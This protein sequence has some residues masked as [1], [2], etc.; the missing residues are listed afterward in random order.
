LA[1]LFLA[2]VVRAQSSTDWLQFNGD[3]QRS[4]ANYAETTIDS[5]NV[6]SLKSV[7]TFTLAN[8]TD[9]AP[10]VLTGV[11][12]SSGVRDLLFINSK[13][14]DF[15]ALDAHTG[16]EIWSAKAAGGFNNSSPAIDPNRLYVY[17]PGADG[18]VHKYDVATGV[19]VT[20]GGFPEMITSASGTKIPGALGIATDASGVTRLYGTSSGF[21]SAP[22]GSITAIDLATGTQNVFNM[23]CSNLNLHI[24]APGNPGCGNNGGGVWSRSG[25]V[26]DPATNLIYVATAEF[27]AFSPSTHRWSQTLLA[28]NPDATNNNGNPVDSNTPTN[29][30]SEISGDIDYGSSNAVVMPDLPGSTVAHVVLMCGKDA[31]MRLLNANNLSGQGGPGH[32]GGDLSDTP[33][34]Q[35]GE[36]FSQF[37]LWHEPSDNSYWVIASSTK[38]ISGLIY[39]LDSANRPTLLPQWHLTNGWVTSPVVANS[40]VFAANEAGLVFALDVK[41]G[42]QLWSAT[43]P[44]RHWSSPVVVNGMLYVT[45]GFTGTGTLSAFGLP[46]SGSPPNPP[47]NLAATAVSS[48]QINLSWTASTT[49]GVTYSIFRS[50]TSGFTPSSSN[51]ITS[52]VSGTTYSD[53][54][55]LTASTT[56]F[57]LAEAVGSGGTSTKSNQASATTL[58]GASCTAVPSAPTALS[59]TAASSSQINLNWT[60]STAGTGCS[61]A[62]NVYSSTTSGFTPSTSNQIASNL[63]STSFSNTGLAASTTY[64]Y[65]VEAVDSDGSSG[66]SNQGSATTQ[67]GGSGGTQIIAI[68]AGG[69]VEGSFVADEDFSGGATIDHANTINTSKVTNPAPAAVYQSARDAAT[70]APFS[71]TIPGFVAGDSYLV[72]LH[73][74]ETFFTTKGSRVFNVSINGT[75]VL[76]N[77]DIVAASGGENIAN[78]QQFTENANSSGQFVISFTSVTNNALISGIEIDSTS[79]TPPPPSCTT[80]CIDSGSTTGSAP[81]VADEDFTSGSTI[82]HANTIN[83]SEVTNPA[84]EAV[85]QS[86]R[87]GAT[88]ASGV[89]ATFSYTI[90]G[91]TA[92]SSHTVRLHFAETFFTTK[93]SRVFNV[94]INGTQVLTNFDI[95]A[96]AGGENIANIQQFPVTA[97]ASGN[98]TITFTSVTNN[99]LI[100][101]IEIN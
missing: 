39:T 99:A 77:F 54:T 96:A 60:A 83:L 47:T 45:S 22:Y 72:R 14:G 23:V 26:Y 12:T 8:P 81:F 9:A 89:G 18:F 17:M 29:Y 49:S 92:A 5:S 82:D 80:L 13:D 32:T 25:E 97:D 10:V 48:S 41:T 50:T 88:Q 31:Q 71:Y 55:G 75:Q 30:A 90:S 38:G 74:A 79:S 52:D 34:P 58:A 98:I 28:I 43:T 85:Y 64:F 51:E 56:Y 94:S 63:N 62:Y 84:P 87:V 57:Y 91:L 6:G 100:S 69:P 59:A 3:Q 19:E 40:I 36:A 86:A 7:F 61:V 67:S 70:G 42:G 15:Y 46:S 68:N 93:G 76:T 2:N 78:I 95:V 73:F 66:P 44:S 4:G 33:L 21:G 37:A 53:T 27:G 16:M 11:S 20:G 65:L 35:G 24:A 101:G 1:A